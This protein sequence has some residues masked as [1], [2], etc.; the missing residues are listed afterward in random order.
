MAELLEW[1]SAVDF[2]SVVQRAAD[3]LGQGKLVAFPT[4]T[5]YGIAAHVLAPEAVERLVHV[6]GRPE[7]KPLTLA[8]AHGVQATDWAPTLSQIA[9]RLA[10]RCWRGPLTLVCGAGVRQG[11]MTCLPEL[12]QRRLCPVGTL[13]LRVPDHDAIRHVM[14]LLGGPLVLPS[15]NRSG[16]TAAVDAG[17]VLE[18][19]GAG[20][21]LVIDGGPSRYGPAPPLLWV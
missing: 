16:G 8:L 3:A 6:K 1:P 20:G 5:V 19:V 11:L 2:W 13:G 18:A 7:E 17:Q 15:A 4:E 12:V 21:D 9:R 10:R 14:Q